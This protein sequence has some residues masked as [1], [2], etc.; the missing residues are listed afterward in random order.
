MRIEESCMENT[1]G[2]HLSPYSFSEPKINYKAGFGTS[3]YGAGFYITLDK[4]SLSTFQY[5]AE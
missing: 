2:Y 4:K 3:F 5:K 1:Y